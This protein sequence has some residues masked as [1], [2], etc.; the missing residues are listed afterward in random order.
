MLREQRFCNNR[1]AAGL[2][3]RP[4]GAWGMLPSTSEKRAISGIGESLVFGLCCNTDPA[5]RSR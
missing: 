1:V 5:C 2:G 3:L 4:E